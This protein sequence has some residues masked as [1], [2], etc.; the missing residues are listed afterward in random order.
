MF[1]G[2]VSQSK[3]QTKVIEYYVNNK[4]QKKKERKTKKKKD[5]SKAECEPKILPV[6]ILEENKISANS[7]STMEDKEQSLLFEISAKKE[8][9]T[10]DKH[11]KQQWVIPSLANSISDKE[12]P[13]RL[14][15]F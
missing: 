1:H 11:S 9:N 15:K 14:T 12:S 10:K 8:S 6:P 3:Y 2:N 5:V 13:K 4:K 7:L